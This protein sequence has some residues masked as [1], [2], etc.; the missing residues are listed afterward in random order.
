[1][2]P[3]NLDELLE[4]IHT[5]KHKGERC[6]GYICD[7]NWNILGLYIEYEKKNGAPIDQAGLLK[8]RKHFLDDYVTKEEFREYIIYKSM[9]KIWDKEDKEDSE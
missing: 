6:K 3:K 7:Y 4:E 2:I 1:M 8:L 5:M 9:M